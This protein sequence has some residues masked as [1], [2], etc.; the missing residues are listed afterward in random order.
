M[1][2]GKVFSVFY[3]LAAEESTVSFSF[4]AVAQNGQPLSLKGLGCLCESLTFLAQFF[5]SAIR[6]FSTLSKLLLPWALPGMECGR[7]LL[8][9][10]LVALDELV[11]VVR[12]VNEY[13]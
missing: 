10:S 6:V 11:L 4:T 2:T 7:K 8:D 1:R 9:D 13:L 12:K 5:H 3:G